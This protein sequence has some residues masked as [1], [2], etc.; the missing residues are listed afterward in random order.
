MRA[1]P[2]TSEG[3]PDG[4]AAPLQLLTATAGVGMARWGGGR[5]NLFEALLIFASLCLGL[6]ASAWMAGDFG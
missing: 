3:S 5:V 6:I 4:R 1:H 2:V